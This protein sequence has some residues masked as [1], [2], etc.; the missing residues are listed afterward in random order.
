MADDDGVSAELAAVRGCWEVAAL[1]QFYRVCGASLELPEQ[2]DVDALEA[3]LVS[4]EQ[5]AYLVGLL[6][7][8]LGLGADAN[9]PACWRQVAES[10][11]SGDAVFPCDEPPT[12]F[13]ALSP[14]D[15]G[16]LLFA[17]ADASL[18]MLQRG[19]DYSD[20]P[21]EARGEL[22]GTDAKGHSYWSLGDRRIYREAP[23]PP[24]PA[25]KKKKTLAKLKG[26][27]GGGGGSSGSGAPPPPPPP[28][29][30]PAAEWTLAARTSTD[31]RGLI[32]GLKKKGAEGAL[33]A[34]LEERVESVEV[35]VTLTRTRTL[36]LT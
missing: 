21:S 1:A 4:D 3:A 28:P 13:A 6:P 34:A 8:L 29:P 31:W 20:D 33:R 9:A 23:P 5:E 36:T 27:G 16:R 12:S 18:M 2:P 11:A 14:A 7:P 19:P 15:R 35:T 25:P 22:I 26:K 24:A 30:P 10:L 32:G 17:I